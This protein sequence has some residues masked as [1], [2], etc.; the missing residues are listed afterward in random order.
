MPGQRV[1]AD[2]CYYE[3][4]L[5]YEDNYKT[6]S[7]SSRSSSP[8]SILETDFSVSESSESP[9]GS[10]ISDFEIEAERI[11]NDLDNMK[12]TEIQAEEMMKGGVDMRHV[13]QTAWKLKPKITKKFKKGVKLNGKAVMKLLNFENYNEREAEQDQQ[14]RLSRAWAQ[15]EKMTR[16]C[17]APP[18]F[19]TLD[20]AVER[21]AANTERQE[22]L[23]A[24]ANGT[25]SLNLASKPITAHDITIS[26]MVDTC[27]AFVQQRKNPTFVGLEHLEAEMVSCYSLQAAAAAPLLRP[28]AEGS[29][30]AVREAEDRCYRCQVTAFH[31]DT[32]T[33]DIKFVDHGGYTTVPASQLRQLRPDFLRLPF[34]AIEVY[35]AHVAPA[36]REEQ[37]D[38][39]AELLFQSSVSLQLLGKAEDGLPMV[40]AYYYEGEYINLLSQE[41]VDSLSPAPASPTWVPEQEQEPQEEERNEE[42]QKE[43]AESSLEASDCQPNIPCYPAQYCYP[44]PQYIQ[45][46]Y[47]DEA[48]QPQV[49]YYLAGPYVLPT[50][51]TWCPATTESPL[52]SSDESLATSEESPDSPT[53]SSSCSESEASCSTASSYDFINKPFEEWTEEDYTHYYGDA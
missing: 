4:T 50:P 16:R 33:A 44:S 48:G 32:D 35:F 15:Y 45:C 36:E 28:I 52:P 34:Q 13:L 39:V 41:T 37:I 49:C 42:G 5:N 40:Q 38:L 29:V 12:I 47:Q 26:C 1:P 31:P 10:V 19:D 53:T 25:N 23:V 8:K 2:T 43:T 51:P 46:V 14:A 20:L 21:A 9:E 11:A 22:F 17:R 24:Y 7:L 30:L 3:E 18:G 6:E 27:R